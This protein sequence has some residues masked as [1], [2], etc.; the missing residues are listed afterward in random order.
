MPID[1]YEGMRKMEILLKHHRNNCHS[2]DAQ[3]NG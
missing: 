3:I 2:M 1:K